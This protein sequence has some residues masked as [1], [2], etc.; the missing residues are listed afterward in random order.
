MADRKRFMGTLAVS[1]FVAL[2]AGCGG[3]DTSRAPPVTSVPTPSPTPTPTPP[4]PPFT[5]VLA[6]IFE[7][8]TLTS[9][10]FITG[11][12]WLRDTLSNESRELVIDK[13]FLD[14]S[15]DA[16]VGGYR[17]T[18]TE[19]GSGI[20]M[21]TGQYFPPGLAEPGPFYG[22]VFQAALQGQSDPWQFGMTM[23]E[24]RLDSDPYRYV[25]VFDPYK[26]QAR[27]DGTSRESWAWV[28][29]AQQ[30]PAGKV[31]T[32]G[33]ARYL[34]DLA[35]ATGDGWWTSVVGAADFEVDYASRTIT[36]TFDIYV[37]CFMGCYYPPTRYTLSNGTLDPSD[38]TITTEL[39]GP[40]PGE[41][42]G[43][44]AGPA[45]DE[46]LLRFKFAFNNPEVTQVQQVGGVVL[47]RKT[48]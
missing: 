7:N 6:Q 38:G 20:V 3:D 16:A 8:P 36:G 4:P 22:S 34:G 11:G 13:T 45:G 42:R 26:Y 35:G 41:L 37:Q 47:L 24:T 27:P 23:M 9:D 29:A 28:G 18:S 12:G 46:A 19:Y 15:W 21:R 44:L 17:M 33:V 10:F 32:T 14:L 1:I 40:A 31:P 48:P 25:T 2:T 39:A 30:T 5:P 43:V